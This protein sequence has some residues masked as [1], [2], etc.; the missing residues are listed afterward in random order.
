MRWL[1]ALQFTVHV[2]RLEPSDSGAKRFRDVRLRALGESPD[3]FGTTLA[4]ASARDESVWFKQL[5]EIAT[6]VACEDGS[7]I[8]LVRGDAV[9]GR[10]EAAILLSL[11]VSNAARGRGVGEALIKAVQEWAREKGFEQLVL[12]VGDHNH[13][14]IRLYERLGFV[15]TGRRT[16]LEP[17]RE[18]ITEHE[19]ALSL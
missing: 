16:T 18:H 9:K 12:E 7:D 15:P 8:G 13:S 19:R 4:E 11:W 1:F 5:E 14:A 6:F 2:D 3:S 17:P 10:Q